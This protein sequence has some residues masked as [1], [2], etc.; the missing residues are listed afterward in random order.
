MS[1]L[2]SNANQSRPRTSTRIITSTKE[3]NMRDNPDD[4]DQHANLESAS[5]DM[6][7]T[8]MQRA[9]EDRGQRPVAALVSD[10]QVAELKRRDDANAEAAARGAILLEQNRLTGKAWIISA[11]IL[12]MKSR[13]GPDFTPGYL[14]VQAL[15]LMLKG[16]KQVPHEDPPT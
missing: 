10:A 3:W 8:A 5:S 9:E 13:R 14:D 6:L 4:L 15:E 7:A 16:H 2:R 12:A 1:R 11:W